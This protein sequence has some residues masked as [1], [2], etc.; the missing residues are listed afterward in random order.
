[1]VIKM[2]RILKNIVLSFLILFL[3]IGC[4]SPTDSDS[5]GLCYYI[6][7]TGEIHYYP[8]GGSGYG[9]DGNYEGKSFRIAV[10]LPDTVQNCAYGVFFF[11]DTIT[12]ECL[13]IIKGNCPNSTVFDIYCNVSYYSYLAILVSKTQNHPIQFQPKTGDYL[14]WYMGDGIYPGIKSSYDYPNIYAVYLYEVP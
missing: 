8:C 12:Y 9:G 1:M 6:G 14:G 7:E 10:A 13:Q 11:A 5:D 4:E 3:F 2:G